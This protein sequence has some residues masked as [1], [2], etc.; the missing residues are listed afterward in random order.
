[1]AAIHWTVFLTPAVALLAACLAGWI[2]LQNLY[3][4]RMKLRSDLYTRRKE[5]FNVAAKVLATVTVRGYL[6]RDDETEYLVGQEEARWLFREDVVLFLNNFSA[7]ISK[8]V[9]S[10]D[11]EPDRGTDEFRKWIEQQYVA[12]EAVL[13]QRNKLY[14]LFDPY[15]TI[16]DYAP[17]LDPEVKKIADKSLSFLEKFM[18]PWIR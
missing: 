2:G 16:I 3:S 8:L 17:G 9:R 14:D 6:K 7:L 13:A 15:L 10:E 18:F 5:V 12:R 11:D 1:M 4:A